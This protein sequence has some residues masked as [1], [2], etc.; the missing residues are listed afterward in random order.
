M[1]LLDGLWTYVVPFIAVLTVLVFVHEMGHLSCGAA[2]RCAGL[3]CF[4]L[5]LVLRFLASLPRMG[6]VGNS[7]RFRLAAMS[8]CLVNER[9][10]MRKRP[11]PSQKRTRRYRFFR[12]H[13]DSAPGSCLPVRWRIS[14]LQSPRLPGCSCSSDNHLRRRMSAKSLKA[15]PRNGLV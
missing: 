6:L 10:K 8:E 14:C 9:R 1:E 13:W 4:P 7:A 12:R 2:L 11:K 5:V 15:P 3:K